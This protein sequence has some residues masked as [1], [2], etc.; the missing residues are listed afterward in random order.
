MLLFTDEQQ[1]T[2][3]YYLY[4]LSIFP[5]LHTS[6]ECVGQTGNAKEQF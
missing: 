1:L 3:L 5:N 6:Q 4:V 2:E